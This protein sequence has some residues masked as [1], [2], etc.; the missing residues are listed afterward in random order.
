MQLLFFLA[1]S[2]NYQRSAPIR[3]Q[4][5]TLIPIQCNL[6]LADT[7]TDTDT[8]LNIAYTD[9]AIETGKKPH[10]DTGTADMPIPILPM[11]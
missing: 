5:L 10:A 6:N 4:P 1:Y 11:R 7:I 3:H 9:S 8:H 2:K